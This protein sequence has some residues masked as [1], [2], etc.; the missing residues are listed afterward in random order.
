MT[1]DNHRAEPYFSFVK[2]GQKTVEGRVK[3][4]KYARI[5]PG[6]HIVVHNELET[7]KVEVVVKRITSYRTIKEM[8]E[9]ENIK[10]LLPGVRTVE[11]GI[12]VYRKFY[13][14]E[15]EKEFGVVAIEVG[16]AD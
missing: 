3:K 16:R 2:N 13:T 8:L 4:G 15:Q 9:S 10:N 1:Y 11:G 12:E 14:P 6:D 7:D 5:K